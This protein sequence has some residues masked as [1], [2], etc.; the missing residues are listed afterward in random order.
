MMITEPAQQASV[1]DLLGRAQIPNLPQSVIRLFELARD[2]ENGPAEF[3]AAIDTDLNL[4]G[5]VLRFV[6][7]GYFGFSREIATVKLGVSL[8]GI[9][10]IKYFA[11]GTSILSLLPNPQCG[12]FDAKHLWQDS[13]RRGLFARAM[14]KL[15]GLR[16]AE[17]V[18]AAALV[19][20]LAIPLLVQER[21]RDYAALFTERDAS[22][23]RLSDLERER[24]GTDHAEVGGR[25]ARRWNLSNE[26]ATMV[27]RH[28]TVDILAAG[29]R[30]HWG[31]VAVSLSSLLPALCDDTW[32]DFAKFERTFVALRPSGTPSLVNVLEGVDR[33]FSTLA[34][35]LRLDVP[36]KCLADF[37]RE[38][39]NIKAA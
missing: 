8:V 13:L 36:S 3:A 22:R 16:E 14:G 21:S 12:S 38:A 37:Y 18:F 17:D 19:Q 24:F 5:Q 26:F 32:Y 28:T 9:R 39:A 2:P 1:D 30:T 20:D 15:L 34:P 27:E 29:F 4:A 10:A 23:R 31:R 7:S 11:L 35:V 6:N 33:H 25:I